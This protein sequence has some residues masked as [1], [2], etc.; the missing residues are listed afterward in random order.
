ME[1]AA[2]ASGGVASGTSSSIPQDP[3]V[4]LDMLQKRCLGNR[5]L[6]AMA[7]RKFDSCVT[8]D[9]QALADSLNRGDAKAVAA[10]AHKIK[11][12]AANVSAE[13]VRAV[14]T[15]LETLAHADQLAQSLACLDQLNNEM[16]QFRAYLET[17]FARLSPVEETK[18]CPP[19]RI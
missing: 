19:L 16:D 2:E 8:S 3:P 7:L 17:A 11:G 5:K 1:R 13:R 6:A 9:V 10:A 14:V 18:P 15:Q 4:D 12:A